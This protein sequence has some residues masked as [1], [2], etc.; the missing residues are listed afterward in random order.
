MIV[1]I[2]NCWE[3]KRKERER[4]ETKASLIVC[5]WG[6]KIQFGPAL[7]YIFSQGL[8]NYFYLFFSRKICWC[9]FKHSD[10]FYLFIY[11]LTYLFWVSL[12]WMQKALGCGGGRGDCMSTTPMQETKRKNIP[13]VAFVAETQSAIRK[14]SHFVLGVLLLSIKS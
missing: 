1:S 8:H 14:E 11:L 5:Y 6:I 12:T 7:F 10:R 9:V 4:R 3:E 13:Y 2:L